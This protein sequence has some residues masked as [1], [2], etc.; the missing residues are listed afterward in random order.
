MSLIDPI[1]VV[2]IQGNNWTGV[3]LCRR[4]NGLILFTAFT[5]PIQIHV[6][7]EGNIPGGL[8]GGL[9]QEGSD[10]SFWAF[11]QH[12][13]GSVP[14]WL[15]RIVITP[16]VITT[17]APPAP[18]E[19]FPDLPGLAWEVHLDDEFRTLI[20][21]SNA[22]G[23]ESRI[24]KGPDAVTHIKLHYNFLRQNVN[25]SFFAPAVLTLTSDMTI[26]A[27]ANVNLN[28]TNFANQSPRWSASDSTVIFCAGIDV[29]KMDHI[30]G[31]ATLTFT[32][33]DGG[34]VNLSNV[35][36]DYVLAFTAQHIYKLDTATLTLQATWA[37][38]SFSTLV[39]IEQ[40]S[41]DAGGNLAW[42]IAGKSGGGTDVYK[43]DLVAVA[44]TRITFTGTYN[45]F[46]MAIN[47]PAS[48]LDLVDGATPNTTSISIPSGAIATGTT[49]GSST[50]ALGVDPD[51]FFWTSDNFAT[52]NGT[53]SWKI[54]PTPNVV[55]TVG[56]YEFAFQPSGTPRAQGYTF[57]N[58]VPT[59]VGPLTY[60]VT[61]AADELAIVRSYWR[62]KQ[63]DAI[64]F[65]L[66]LSKITKNPA[67]P[68]LRVRFEKG[69]ADFKAFLYQLYEL[70]ELS[71]VTVGT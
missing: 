6:N 22:P 69:S 9:V 20:Q 63:G 5:S 13:I 62:S 1:P 45:G 2:L 43:L 47:I 8:R 12:G 34:T 40:C 30:T 58:V 36:G 53:P 32:A 33:P 61:L 31:A 70:Q 17:S 25:Q 18:V 37:I 49:P 41:F 26:A 27:V 4:D 68:T 48:T 51:G 56:T 35:V 46:N 55:L 21:R 60:P 14:I 54:D 19:T 42:V 29:Y 23:Y 44:P 7:G 11:I 57:A 10:P 50:G 24:S 64:S 66:P 67:D 38:T 39:G 71:F 59:I 16:P 65:S 52:D 3:A 15:T 28:I